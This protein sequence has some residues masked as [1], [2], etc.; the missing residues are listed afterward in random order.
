MVECREHQ[1]DRLIHRGE[2]GGIGTPLGIRN[3]DEPFVA[4]WRSLERRMH[5]V[6]RKIEKKW[7][8]SILLSGDE[9]GRLSAKSF[10]E[11]GRLGDRF[12]VAQD[13]LVIAL[14]I[15]SARGHVCVA[16]AEET[17]KLVET[18]IHRREAGSFA[19]MPLSDHGCGVARR[20]Q[21]G[22]QS[23]HGGGQRA[24]EILD[25]AAVLVAATH[26]CRTCRRAE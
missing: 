3:P 12:A 13:R 21:H 17:E 10:G 26:E 18:P 7:L 4:P 8:G 14:A 22:R 20:T 19:E 11:V 24:L 1:S 16:A 2:H 23:F 25:A 15:E 5:G 9:G 6:E